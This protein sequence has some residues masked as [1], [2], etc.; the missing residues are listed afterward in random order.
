M[1]EGVETKEMG[2]DLSFRAQSRRAQTMTSVWL[3]EE[4]EEQGSGIN[5]KRQL[6][7]NTV[8][9]L[10]ENRVNDENIDP[11]LGINLV[12]SRSQTR[13]VNG[14][15]SGILMNNSMDHDLEDE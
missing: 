8:R 13:E 7:R 3:Q 11:I 1:A 9:D 6:R 14:K 4:G 2:W 15:W 10:A 5:G 12:G